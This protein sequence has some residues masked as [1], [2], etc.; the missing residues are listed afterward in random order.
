[1]NAIDTTAQGLRSGAGAGA[2]AVQS[3][4]SIGR[5]TPDPEIKPMFDEIPIEVAPAV[6]ES[7]P[8]STWALSTKKGK[9]K[10][11]KGRGKAVPEIVQAIE[12]RAVD[13]AGPPH[14][15]PE[16]SVVE[17]D[18]LEAPPALGRPPT[19]P[20]SPPLPPP[21]PPLVLYEIGQ[22][23]VDTSDHPLTPHAWHALRPPFTAPSDSE[24]NPSPPAPAAMEILDALILSIEALETPGVKIQAMLQV[25]DG[26]RQ[27]LKGL[28]DGGH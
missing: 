8:I 12:D 25:W 5:Q 3:A 15:S 22:T 7:E 4:D 6:P 2:A 16:L 27:V 13:I 10:K 1:M 9:G 19:P 14:L 28:A 20:Q 23:P 18:L 26:M 17:Q 21:T 11:K 24:V